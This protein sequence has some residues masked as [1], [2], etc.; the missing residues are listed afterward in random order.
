MFIPDPT[1]P[2][3]A[4]NVRAARAIAVPCPLHEHLAWRYD[5]DELASKITAKTRAIYVN[6]PHNP[7]GGVLRRADVEAIAALA[8]RRGVWVLSDE[9]Y[10]DVIFDEA[11]HVSP[12]SLPYCSRFRAGG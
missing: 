2:P 11:E 6:S 3:C 10:E 5:L 12:A 8:R 7:T 1:W 4:G 9:S